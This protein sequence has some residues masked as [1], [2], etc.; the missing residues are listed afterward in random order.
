MIKYDNF[1][2]QIIAL[3]TEYFAAKFKEIEIHWYAQLPLLVEL[4][5]VNS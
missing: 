3:T 4:P 2:W 1:Q 5:I